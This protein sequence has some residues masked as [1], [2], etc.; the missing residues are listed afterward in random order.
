[1]KL[2]NRDSNKQELRPQLE[3]AKFEKKLTAEQQLVQ[4]DIVRVL[5]RYLERAKNGEYTG[6][7]IAA[8]RH[9]NNADTCSSATLNFVAQL[10]AAH[11]ALHRLCLNGSTIDEPFVES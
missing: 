5:E 3:L 2:F 4:D 10:G 7:V 6:V 9:D 8:A 1:M 11:Y